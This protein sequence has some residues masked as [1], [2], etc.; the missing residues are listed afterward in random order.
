MVMMMVMMMVRWGGLDRGEKRCAELVVMVM[1]TGIVW[2]SKTRRV[3][4]G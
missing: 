3:G 2:L 1:I 4:R